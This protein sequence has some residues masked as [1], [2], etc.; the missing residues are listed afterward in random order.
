FALH[1]FKFLND[2][3]PA[4]SASWKQMP[5]LIKYFESKGLENEEAERAAAATIVVWKK[6]GMPTEASKRFSKT[7]NRKEF[8]D[9][10]RDVID[11]E[12]DK[13]ILE[14]IDEE[15]NKEYQKTKSETI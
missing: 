13:L 4:A 8:I 5:F 7:G 2:G 14:G 3:V 10:V 1:Y 11:T 9:M 6:E 15:I 12:T